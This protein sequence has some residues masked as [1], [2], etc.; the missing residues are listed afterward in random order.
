MLREGA[1]PSIF[2]FSENAPTETVVAYAERAAKRQKVRFGEG[3]C[4]EGQRDEHAAEDRASETPDV[5][6]EIEIGESRSPDTY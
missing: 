4:D 3:E 6:M 5:G 2:T 1:V